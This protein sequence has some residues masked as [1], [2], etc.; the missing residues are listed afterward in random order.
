MLAK[1]TVDSGYMNSVWGDMEGYKQCVSSFQ[2]HAYNEILN[3]GLNIATVNF[4]LPTRTLGGNC[5]EVLSRFKAS[6]KSARKNQY[7]IRVD[8]SGFMGRWPKILFLPSVGSIDLEL[9]LED[10]NKV[11]SNYDPAIA[12]PCE[13]IVEN[14]YGAAEEY[15]LSQSYLGSL[16]NVLATTGLTCEFD[17]YL[18]Y[19]FI[20][21]NNNPEQSVRL[22][23]R[24]TSLKSIYFGIYRESNTIADEEKKQDNLARFD[25]AGLES[26]QIFLDGRPLSARPISTSTLDDVG[27]Y[28]SGINAGSNFSE[29]TFELMKALRYHGNVKNSPCLDRLDVTQDGLN[30][31]YNN[32]DG[33][34]FKTTCDY[35]AKPFCIYGV[36]L[37]KSQMLSGTNLS[38]ELCIQ[39][40]FRQNFPLVN[41]SNHMHVFLHYDKRVTIHS[42]LRITELE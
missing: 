35:H 16:K 40:K 19:P 27:S 6:I 23:R 2:D 20:L 3:A 36:D 26:Y 29:S 7:T 33:S 41:F 17:S 37:E 32:V 5:Y 14:V 39:L 9:R 22:W 24:L 1:P 4:E 8:L 28:I 42:G 10:N 15:D 18:S 31:V 34:D 11:L 21:K 25:K 30:N 38:N 13:Y 12:G